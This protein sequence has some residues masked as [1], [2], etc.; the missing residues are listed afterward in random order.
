[1]TTKQQT[2]IRLFDLVGSLAED[3]DAAQKLRRETL[4]PLV[5]ERHKV[6]LDFKGVEDATQSFIHAL[7]SELI[8]ET[9]G[10]ALDLIYFKNCNETVKIIINMVVDYMT[11]G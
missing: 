2:T 3:K 10:E 11:T 5:K 7:L 6:I 8:R 4:M 9:E 1:M